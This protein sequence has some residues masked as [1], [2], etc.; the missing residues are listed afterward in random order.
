MFEMKRL[1]RIEMR[2]DSG[3]WVACHMEQ[4]EIGDVVRMF[5]PD[6]AEVKDLDGETVWHVTSYP[7]FDSEADWMWTLG[8]NVEEYRRYKKLCQG[9]NVGRR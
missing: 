1:R 9:L 5:H 7:S 8:K 4:L 3:Q 2:D 6:G